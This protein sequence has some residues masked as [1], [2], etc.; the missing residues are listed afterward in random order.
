MKNYTEKVSI[1]IPAYNTSEYIGKCLDSIENQTYQNIEIIIIDDGSTD[2][3]YEIIQDRAIATKKEYKVIRQQNSGQS[4]ARNRGLRA[5]TGEFIVFVDSD[6]WLPNENDIEKMIDRIVNETADFVQCSFEFVKGDTHSKYYVSQKQAISGGQIL[7]DMLNVT[8]LYTSP[9]AKIYSTSFLRS[10]K[11]FFMEGLVNEDT[12]FSILVASKASRVAFLHDIVYCSRERE[13]STSRSSFIRMFKTMHEV[14]TRT[15]EELK[16]NPIFTREIENLFDGRYVRSM[17]Y[18]L[19]QTGQRS[20]YKI[21]KEDAE[22]CFKST[23]YL[24]KLKYKNYLPLKHRLLASISRNRLLF[25][26][27]GKSMKYLGKQMH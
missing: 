19:L 7:I 16:Q 10:N 9:W 6:D 1:I 11:L 8:D 4:I 27:V 18:N 25:F 2:N 17:L 20:N 24:S 23:D 21:F 14:L 3:T 26:V 15:K 22:Y 13:G 5:A 12:G